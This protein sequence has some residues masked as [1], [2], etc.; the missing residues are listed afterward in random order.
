MTG[1]GLVGTGYWGKN[2]ARNW[3]EML[4]EGIID[5][6]VF[7]DLDEGRVKELAGDDIRWT[8]DYKEILADPSIDAVDIVTPSNTHYPLGL[9]A[10]SAGKDVF[11]E[12]PLTMCSEEAEKL[13][14]AAEENGR[15]LM[16]GHLFR[17]HPGIVKVREMIKNGD[18]GKIYYMYTNRMAYSVPRPDMGVMYALGVHELDLYCYLLG[19]D[20]P[21]VAKI[22][23]GSFLQPGIEE[24][25]SIL[26]EFDDN[27]SGYAIESWISPFDKKIRTFTI[28]GSEMS[29]KVDYMKHDSIETFDGRILTSADNGHS[30]PV[31]SGGSVSEL[32]F[33]PKE[34]LREELLDY[35][36]CIKTRE[37]PLA[38][39]YCG[40]RAVR[41]VESCLEKGY[42]EP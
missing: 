27:I 38:D 23:K 14:Q 18:F 39:M 25:S 41:M 31:V 13:V 10:I 2:H 11:V 32:Y 21:N 4:G 8:T 26:M 15:V 29:A 12:K 1:I 19:V 20:Y 7:C 9:M 5:D 17:Y 34:P 40:K 33:P 24:F 42:F 6:L 37:Q 3:R 35:V 22:T 16:V 36:N 30:I 28:I